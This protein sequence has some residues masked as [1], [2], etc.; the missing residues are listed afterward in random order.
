MDFFI[1]S[2][3][4]YNK[5]KLLKIEPL[6]VISKLNV[7]R[8]ENFPFHLINGGENYKFKEGIYKSL[9]Y[10]YGEYNI[11]GMTALILE[12]F[13]KVIKNKS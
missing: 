7:D 5:S 8:N 2:I 4:F 13:L 11:W 6:K 10:N 1:S 12:D 9:F 3:S